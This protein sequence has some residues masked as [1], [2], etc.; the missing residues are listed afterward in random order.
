VVAAVPWSGSASEKCAPGQLFRAEPAGAA[1]GIGSRPS[2]SHQRDRPQSCARH[3]GRGGLGSGQGVWFAA[4]FFRADHPRPT[5]PSD[6]R[7]GRSSEAH[8]A[9]LAFVDE[10]RGLPVG[11]PSAGR[12]QDPRDAAPCSFLKYKCHAR[13]HALQI[14]R[15]RMD[16]YRASKAW[17]CPG[18]ATEP[19][20]RCW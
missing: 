20:P 12:Q 16:K 15:V 3:A 18:C 5:R 14:P 19:R 17:H 1:V 4:C 6:R 13:R 8:C 11:T 9:L 7:G 10:G 2:R